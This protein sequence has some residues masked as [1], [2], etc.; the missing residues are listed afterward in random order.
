LWTPSHPLATNGATPPAITNPQSNGYIGE[1]YDAESRLMYLHARYDDPLLGRFLTPDTWDPMLAGVDV[2]RYAYA[3]NDPVNGKDANGHILE[4][5]WDA[6]NV[7]YGLYSLGSNLYDGNWREAAWDAGGVIVDA[8]A[9]VIP[10][11]PGGAAT[12]IKVERLA[13]KSLTKLSKIADK[14][15]PSWGSK[16]SGWGQKAGKDSWHA[17]ASYERAVEYAKDPNVAKVYLNKSLDNIMGTKGIYKTR[18][19]ITVVYKDG[20]KVRV[21]ECVSPSQKASDM[22]KKN[23]EAEAKAAK[24]GKTMDSETI[25][26]GGGNDPTGG[27]A[28]GKAPTKVKGNWVGAPNQ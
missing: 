17:D 7:G 19:G 18:P 2:N 27:K 23:S 8:A 22:A 12:A 4:T 15:D 1:R 13:Q 3:N 6:A 9:T 11:V 24:Q 5:L 14:V 21:C 16:I 20:R 10:I 28:T 26:R 25:S